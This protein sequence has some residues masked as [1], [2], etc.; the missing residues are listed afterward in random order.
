MPN[1]RRIIVGH[2][3]RSGESWDEYVHVRSFAEKTYRDA[4]K[5]YVSSVRKKL[6][7]SHLVSCQFCFSQTSGYFCFLF[8]V[9]RVYCLWSVSCFLFDVS[10]V[11]GL[12]KSNL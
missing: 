2:V 10:G 4:E 8:L 12:L 1:K 9:S 7:N 3:K 6:S 5:E 11:W